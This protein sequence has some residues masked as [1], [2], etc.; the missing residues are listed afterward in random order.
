MKKI[1][2]KLPKKLRVGTVDYEILYPFEFFEETSICGLHEGLSSRIKIGI[3]EYGITKS[4]QRIVETFLHEAFHALSFIWFGGELFPDELDEEFTTTIAK[5][6][7]QVLRDN[8]LKLAEKKLYMPKKVKIGPYIYD[9][10]YPYRFDSTSNMVTCTTDNITN[11]LRIQN[12]DSF[13]AEMSDEYIRANLVYSINSA[14]DHVYFNSNC[15]ATSGTVG[16]T[17]AIATT[18]LI[19]DNKFEELVSRL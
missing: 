15:E 16:K 5:A 3:E 8:K 10:V 13:N 7:M 9:V 1:P 19:I 6:W 17:L 4:T 11:T 12:K 2:I 18:G 14:I